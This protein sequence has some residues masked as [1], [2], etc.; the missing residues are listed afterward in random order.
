MAIV[1]QKPAVE[2]VRFSIQDTE[3]L[4]RLILGSQFDGKEVEAANAVLQK[5]KKLH[6]TLMNAEQS[7]M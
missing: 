6:K 7:V 5:I 3:F 1:Q 4:L 2:K